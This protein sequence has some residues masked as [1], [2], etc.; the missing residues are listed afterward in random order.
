MPIQNVKGLEGLKGLYDISVE[1][2]KQFLHDN[3][4]KLAKY[5]GHPITYGT[6][7]ER[8][9]NNQKFKDIF[10]VEAFNKLNDNTKASYDYRN[11]LVKDY[12]VN[13]AAAQFSPFDSKGIRDNRRG[14]GEYWETFNEMSTDGKLKV[15]RSNWLSPAEFEK[16][17]QKDYQASTDDKLGKNGVWRMIGATG[18]NYLNSANM[19]EAQFSNTTKRRKL[20]L[21]QKI[22]DT[23]NNDDI[24]FETS[25]QAPLVSKCYNELL[26]LTDEQVKK[27]FIQAI[28]P[29]SFKYEN[30]MS[31]LGIGPY[32]AYYGNGK[33]GQVRDEMANFSIEQMREVLAKK[34]AYEATMSPMRAKTALEN[35]AKRYIT[36]HQTYWAKKGKL[37]R[38]IGISSMSYT[39]DKINSVAEIFRL[40]QDAL[41]SEKPQVFVDDNNNIIDTTKVKLTRDAKGILRYT[42]KE[43]N[44]HSVHKEQV[45]YTTLHNLGKNTD[46]SD[47]QGAASI[48]WMTL[49]PQYWSRAEQ[50]GTLDD[51]EQKQ[52]E[53]LGYSP[54]KVMYNPN[55]DSDIWYETWKMASFGIADGIAQ[56]IP[57][58]VG[59]GFGALSK[60]QKVGKVVRGFSNVMSETSKLLTAETKFGRVVQGLSGAGGIAYAYER[61]SFPE[62][63]MQNTE[64]MEARVNNKLRNDIYNRYHNDKEYQA[65]IDKKI[66]AVAEVFKKDYLAKIK[67][68]DM[69]SPMDATALDNVIRSKAQDYVMAEELQHST[70]AFKETK[71]YADMQQKAIEGAGNVAFNTFWTEA[72]KYGLVNT[73]GPR[74]FLYQNPAGVTRS[75]SSSLKGLKEITTKEGRK[76]LATEASKFLTNKDKWK[77]FGKTAGSQMWGGAWTNGTDD[78]QVDAAEMINSDSFNRY[79]DAWESGDAAS[80]TYGYLDGLYSYVKGLQDSLGQETTWNAGLVGLMGSAFNMTPNFVNIASLFTKKGRQFYKDS[81]RRSIERDPNTGEPLKNA[82]GSIKYKEYSKWH[83]PLGQFNFFI[84]NGILSTY[85]GKKQAEKDLQSHAD[86]VNELLDSYNDF[87]D[88]EHLIAS[89]IATNNVDGE[90][91]GITSNY[92]KAILAIRALNNLAN[93]SKDP[94][95]MSSVIQR[96]KNLVDKAAQLNTEEGKNIFSDEEIERILSQYYAQN[97]G[98]EQ[99]DANSQK[100]LYTIAQNAQNLQKAAQA[101]SDA[102]KEIDKLEKRYGLEISHQVKTKMVL[103]QALGKHWR[104][105]REQL[106]D[107]VGDTSTNEPP[108]DNSI[109]IAAVGGRKAAEALVKVYNKQQADMEKDLAEQKEKT[110]KLKEKYQ[111]A[112]EALKEAQEKNDSKNILQATEAEKEARA[113]YENSQ[114]TEKYMGDLIQMTIGKRNALQDTKEAELSARD[115]KAYSRAQGEPATSQEK[116]ASLKVERKKY[117][118]KDGTPKKRY[119]DKVAEIDKLIEQYESNIASRTETV[120]KYKERVL[121]ADEIFAL[122]PVTRAKMM[123]QETRSLYSKEQ[124]REIE[125]LEERLLT[126]DADALQ[127][128]QD[129]GRLTQRINSVEDAYT[130]MAKNPE[131]A[132]YN[133]E[134]QRVIAM[135]SA[136]RLVNQRNAETLAGVVNEMSEALKNHLD[137]SQDDVAQQVYKLLRRYSAG[138]LDIIEK[139]NLLPNFTQQLKDAKEWSKVLEDID[140]VIDS[141]DKLDIEKENLKQNIENILANSTTREQIMSELEKVVDDVK[142]P[143]VT[144][145]FE[146]VLNGMAKLGYQRDATRIESRKERLEREAKAKEKQEAEKKR[147][148]EE[149]KAAAEK[150][151]ESKKDKEKTEEPSEKN[152]IEGS[153]ERVDLGLEEEGKDKTENGQSEEQQKGKTADESKSNVSIDGDEVSVVTQSIEEQQKDEELTDK[154]VTVADNTSREDSGAS[155]TIGEQT[156][157]TNGTVLSGVALPYY[158]TESLKKDGIL[159]RRRGEKENDSRNKYQAWMEAAGIKLQNIINHEL[160]KIIALNPHAKVKFMVVK[161]DR[162][163]TNDYDMKTHLMLVLDYD[164]SINKGITGIH[165]DANGGVITSNGKEYL[166]IGTV[167]YGKGNIDKLALYDILWSN[168]PHSSTGYGI[169]RKGMGQ[170]FTEHPSE[171]F[172]VNEDISTEIVPSYPTPGWRVRQMEKDAESTPRS[173]ME[174]L[175][176]KERNPLGLDLDSLGW[177]IQE[178]ST[179]LTVNASGKVMEPQDTMGNLGRAFV[180]IPAGNNKLLPIYLNV[181]KYA[182]MKN[183]TLKDRANTLLQDVVS[184]DYNKRLAATI[185]LSNIF[186]FNKDGDFIL[187]SR[188]KDVI[189]LVHEGKVF[190]TFTLG[191]SF[192]RA[193]FLEAFQEMNPRVNIT[194]KVLSSKDLLKEYNEAGALMTD[195]AM[196]ATAGSSYSIYGVDVDG[197]MLKPATQENIGVNTGESGFRSTDRSQV[198]Y[199]QQYY[200]EADGVFYLNGKPVTD[201]NTNRQLNFIKRILDNGIEPVKSKGVFDYYILSNGE[202][203]E[204]IAVNRNTKEVKEATEEQAKEIIK[205]EEER[206][207]K[208]RR[209]KE[210]AKIMEEEGKNIVLDNEEKVDLG[211]E[212]PFVVDPETGEMIPVTPNTDNMEEGKDKEDNKDTE[213]E[214]DK[215]TQQGDKTNVKH[216]PIV[217]S[218]LPKDSTQTFKTLVKKPKYMIKIMSIV[219]SKWKD[220]PADFIE[221]EKFLKEK[222]IEVDSIGTSEK[223]IENWLNTLKDCR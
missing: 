21:N 16:Q 159:E 135:Q 7:A 208:E 132:A 175:A 6:V 165:N 109:M 75:L 130:R 80:F 101:F 126:K 49:N 96:V 183:G 13:K 67:A 193:E 136:A 155:N 209:E 93:S 82:D 170:F 210:A 184:P 91:D 115:A 36:Q 146:F 181:L 43:G 140:A 33:Q 47:I 138:L 62:T 174:L 188:T 219:K 164:N 50:F 205:E 35:D 24:D 42:D 149:A 54:Y 120:N 142:D 28:T 133:I 14:F 55:D 74:K 218:S 73:V 29:G 217:G 137:I 163:A 9:Y 95:S 22:F 171:R 192:D 103:D 176:D 46:G 180:L 127:K 71:E 214:G 162:N 177:G 27:A 186:Y 88:I 201:E 26:G 215:N 52:Y 113:E 66:A 8:I 160:G 72:L 2:R 172:Y 161:A 61:G 143:N 114:Q 166:I 17:W 202:H 108:T 20:D 156:I 203:P 89:D 148:E 100:A 69:V 5:K 122:D 182:E 222:N 38:D 194:A 220:A 200:R 128:I 150:A 92:L 94:A 154:E 45:S 84:Q 110:K 167:G 23:I 56:L 39:A 197:N 31:N 151:A 111:K 63:L 97:E 204:V 124:Q 152:F 44:V 213:A 70:A 119:I 102:E 59:A 118:K 15:M 68:G 195:A 99:S 81:F 178:A 211:E 221:L 116:L 104:E 223:D 10:G 153:E 4:N 131:A 106:M 85:Y 141:S 90:E 206:K 179:F 51:A 185:A 145:D 107:D 125:K 190:K 79:L 157:G 58:G 12:I 77:Q 139:D 105:R 117:L 158:K 60:A 3:A 196:L 86:Y 11:S 65:L 191:D 207:D 25:K 147:I 134:N 173:V 37:A 53:K 78:M 169:M 112:A 34:K 189:S 144:K 121:T 30:G 19:S 57:F 187:L 18:G 76:I 129:I 212:A 168:N 87:T 123:R 198:I 216:T 83:D 40:A 32:A 98:L 48:D 41:S 199:K 1:E 64:T